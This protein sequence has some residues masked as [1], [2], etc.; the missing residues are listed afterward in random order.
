MAIPTSKRANIVFGCLVVLLA[1]T[2]FRLW[3]SKRETDL[4][5]KRESDRRAALT[6][7]QREWED[8]R[9]AKRAKD[10]KVSSYVVLKKLDLFDGKKFSM[11]ILVAEGSPRQEV[12]NLAESLTREFA[13]KYISINIYDSR[14]AWQISEEDQDRAKNGLPSKYSEEE[15]LRRVNSHWLVQIG[16]EAKTLYGE[17][18]HWS[19]EDSHGKQSEEK[20]KPTGENSTAEKGRKDAS[21][22]ANWRTWTDATGTHHIEAKFGSMTGGNA[23][24]IKRDGSVLTLPLEKLSD[25]DKDW[26]A[27]R[28]K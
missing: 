20:Q 3:D 18:V 11:D 2:V 7:L 22:A 17:E 28:S 14:E 25:E 9:D 1:F 24:L 6:P 5:G 4:A 10:A 27:K 23:R 15:L 21:E 12:L 13:D 26:I 8:A 19:A 16:M